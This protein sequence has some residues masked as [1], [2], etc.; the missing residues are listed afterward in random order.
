FAGL[1][2]S[3]YL[4][5]MPNGLD[6][7]LDAP[8]DIRVNRISW[9]RDQ[10][11]LLVSGYQSGHFGLWLIPVNGSPVQFLIADAKEGAPSPDGIH[12]AFTTVEGSA[13]FLLD[14]RTL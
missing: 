10:S 9:Y 13:I 6:R 1:G 11:R 5:A 2:G 4:R 7:P 3:L 12:V 8:P 14:T